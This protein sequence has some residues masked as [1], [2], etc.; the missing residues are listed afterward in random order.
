MGLFKRGQTWWISFSHNGKQVRHSTETNDKKLAEKIYHKIMT[1]VNEGKWFEK[2]PGTTMVF[3]DLMT[4]YMREHSSKNKTPKSH[5]R[6]RSLSNHLIEHFGGLTLTQIVPSI[7]SEYKNKRLEEGAAPKTVVNELVLLGHAF[8]MA[9]NE[10][11]LIHDNPVKKVSRPEVNNT[12]DRWL[13]HEEEAKLLAESP[14]WL[15]EI[16]V[17]AVNTGLRQGEILSLKWSQIDIFRKTLYISEQKN[18]EKDTLPLNRNAMEIL[19]TR[20]RIRQLDNNYVFFNG[21]GNKI[22]A[23]NLLRTFYRV[24]KNAKI[25]NLRFHDLRHTFATRLVQTGVDLY[26]V[27]KL[28][29]WKD[30]SMIKRY[31]HHCSESLRPGVEKLDEFITILSQSNKK[32]VSQN[33]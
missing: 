18:K 27:Q 23:R 15:K 3:E 22:D 10:W 2:L 9:V 6:D 31:A 25:E 5:V 32:G 33:G 30:I 1:E 17:L 29:R 28:G 21:Q 26:T 24:C 16:I 8:K 12:M 19:K 20:M 4:K 7:I 11:E 13:T 14:V